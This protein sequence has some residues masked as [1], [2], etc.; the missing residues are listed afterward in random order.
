MP[1]MTGPMPSQTVSGMEAGPT[2]PPPLCQQ[3][4]TE[5]PSGWFADP[6]QAAIAQ[7]LNQV[8]SASPVSSPMTILEE[9]APTVVGGTPTNMATEE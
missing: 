3:G 4:P 9:T 7:L 8:S 5:G 1:V 6:Q 2:H